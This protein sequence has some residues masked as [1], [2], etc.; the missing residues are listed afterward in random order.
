[1]LQQWIQRHWSWLRVA[2]IVIA[3]FAI[4]YALW[5]VIDH[6]RGWIGPLAGGLVIA[7][8]YFTLGS[9]VRYVDKHD[10]GH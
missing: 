9:T 7:S 1:M 5:M 10:A 4:G 3:A 8:T 2:I 6:Q